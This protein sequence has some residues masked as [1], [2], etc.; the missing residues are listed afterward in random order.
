MHPIT[1]LPRLLVEYIPRVAASLGTELPD[2]SQV[3]DV[4][5][6]TPKFAI[7]ATG[8]I[9]EAR[10]NL[11][12]HYDFEFDVPPTGFPPPL[13]FQMPARGAARRSWCAAT[14]APSG[15]QSSSS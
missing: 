10:V 13:A 7:R 14:S 8:D 4:L 3:A 5:D 6:A 1:D 12:V 9:I 11:K 2:L 15:R